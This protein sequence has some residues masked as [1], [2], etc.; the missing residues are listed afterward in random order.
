MDGSLVITRTWAGVS[1]LVVLLVL[2][3]LLHVATRS[4]LAAD[5]RPEHI[6]QR[7]RGIKSLVIGTDGRASTSKVQALLWTLAIFYAFV[8]L[9]LWGRS[10]SCGDAEVREQPQCEAATRA[11][12]TFTRVVNGDL[13]PEYYV[14]MG[15]PLAAAVAARA[16]TK[17]KV[18][19]G[20]LEKPV[21]EQD[22]K[23][24]VQ[25]LSEVVTNDKGE[26][27]LVDLQYFAFNLLTLSFFFAEF[28]TKPGQ[29]LPDLPATLIALSGVSAGVYTTRKALERT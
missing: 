16:I 23:G 18:E 8:F 11:R 1:A 25:G 21:V 29:G 6:R 22:A 28:L 27:D 17:A 19:D 26:T 7:R 13:Q 24:V 10:T 5:D 14:L 20:V 2:L 12:S 9:L 15:F 3:G 4:K